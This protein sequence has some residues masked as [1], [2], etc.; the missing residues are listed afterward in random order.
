MRTQHYLHSLFSP[1]SIAIIG[2]SERAQSVGAVILGNLLAGGY[3]GRIFPVNPRH[4]AVLGQPCWP[5]IEEVGSRVDLAIIATPARS[6][7]EIM[8]QCGRAGVR[9]AIIVATGF[10]ETGNSGAVLERKVREI[11]RTGNVRILGPNCIGIMRPDQKLNAAY[12]R[13]PAQAGELALVSQSGAMC[14]AVLD[15]AASNQIGFSSLISLGRSTDVDFGEILDYL[16]YDDKT[17]HILI[18]VE[19]I[20]NARQFMSALRSAARVKPVILLK[21]GR[22]PVDGEGSPTADAVFDAAIRRAGVVRVQN[23]DQLFHA[24]KSLSSG[25]RPRGRQLAILT[26]GGGPGVMAADRAGDLGIPLARLASDTTEKLDRLLPRGWSHGGMIDIGGDAT[27]ERYRDALLAVAGDPNV[28]STL[29][30]MAPHAMAEPLAVA[31]A[32]AEAAGKTTQ[33]ICCCWMGGG[34]VA[35]ARQLLENARLPVFP[36]PDT[37][38]ELFHNIAKY[39]RNQKLLVQTPGPA[40]KTTAPRPGNPRLLIE[41]LLA[42]RRSV[43]SVMESK[44]VLSAFGIAVSQTVVAHTPTEAIFIAQQLGFPVAMKIDSPDLA[45]KSEAGGV[46]LNIASTESVLN[47]YQDIVGAVRQRQPEARINGVSIEPHLARANAREIM[48]GTF[49]DPLFGPVITFGAGGAD[50]DLFS[51]RALALPPLNAFL[52]RDLIES[53]RIGQALG[54]A[55]NTPALERTLIEKVLIA[56]S[57][58]VCEL[59]WVRE[60]EIN[61]LIV[62]ENGAIAADARIVIDH[63]HSAEHGDFGHLAICPYPSH[64]LQEW[65]IDGTS[66]FVRPVRPEDAPLEQAFV[67]SMSEES[68]FFRF[69]DSIRELPPTLLARFTQ[70]DYGRE[71]ALLATINDDGKERLVGSARYALSPDGEA[72]EFA[73]AV[74]DDWQKC[75][76]GR[77]LMAALIDCARQAGYRTMVGDVLSSNAKMLRLME[78]FGFSILPHPEDR[79]A[80]RIVKTLGG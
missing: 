4:A 47:A 51:D 66:V 54:Q 2:A 58:L 21:G 32:I 38:I 42:E 33:T 28:H 17:R 16:I 12:T 27:P 24:A 78:S 35:A 14:S 19:Q 34:Q 5:S 69:M 74:A 18:Y 22:H 80:K 26:N 30:L 40:G 39:Y 44:A 41:T 49:R 53:T 71:M 3:K 52:A 73:L 43:L 9:N 15:W 11:A 7:P 13:I 46:R 67:T 72:V 10:S 79:S 20:R 76:L 68:R 36:T 23:V 70:I 25:F 37:A 61:P 1:R 60:L 65:Q 62:D 64:L 63:A 8:A 48:V 57:E 77:R 29:V 59:P 50:N 75:G 55:G 45:Q 6:I 56:I 31:E